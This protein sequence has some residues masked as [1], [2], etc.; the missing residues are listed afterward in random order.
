[1]SFVDTHRAVGPPSTPGVVERLSGVDFRF[2]AL[3]H[4]RRFNAIPIG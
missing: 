4:A 3:L 1:M 2:S